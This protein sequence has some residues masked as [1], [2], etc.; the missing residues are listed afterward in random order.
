MLL[1]MKEMQQIFPRFF[2]FLYCN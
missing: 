1:M 2:E